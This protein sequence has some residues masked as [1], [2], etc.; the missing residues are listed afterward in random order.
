MFTYEKM[1]EKLKVIA[2]GIN[3]KYNYSF[4]IFELINEIWLNPKCFKAQSEQMF[5]RIVRFD[6]E[7]YARSQLLFRKVIEGKTVY[8]QK[9]CTNINPSSSSRINKLYNAFDFLYKEKG[10]DNI[11]N[12]DLIEFFMRGLSKKEKAVINYCYLQEE[13]GREAGK[14]IGI[15]SSYVSELLKRSINK[16]RD[17]I[18]ENPLLEEIQI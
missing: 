10:F 3:K 7:D 14:K 4:D 16:C 8:K 5:N 11:D 18:K 9:Y 12:R 2:H 1:E 6:M 17:K 13:T 15:K